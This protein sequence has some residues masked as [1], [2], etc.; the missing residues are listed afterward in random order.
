MPKLY[1]GA[2]MTLMACV[3]PGPREDGL[4][5]RRL[6]ALARADRGD[7]IL[8]H[9]RQG[10]AGDVPYHDLRAGMRLLELV[11]DACRHAI[12]IGV[13]APRAARHEEDTGHGSVLLA[14]DP[15]PRSV[16]CRAACGAGGQPRFGSRGIEKKGLRAVRRLRRAFS[17]GD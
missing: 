2:A 16:T 10:N 7:E 3:G 5:A 8:V 15:P 14:G 6:R 17:R 13:A 12:G 11:E 1:I 9:M 4:L